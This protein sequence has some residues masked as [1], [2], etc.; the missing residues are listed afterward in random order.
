MKHLIHTLALTLCIGAA[1]SATAGET[2]APAMRDIAIKDGNTRALDGILWYPAEAGTALKTQHTNAVWAGVQA[3]ANAEPIAGNFPLVVLSHGI[4][5]NARNQNWLAVEL[6]KQGYMAVSLNHPGSSTWLRDPDDA[7]Q[8][9]QRPKDVTRAISFLLENP[10]TKQLINPERI[11][12]AGHSLGGMTA[13]QLA[14]ARYSPEKVDGFCEANPDDLLCGIVQM[15]QLGQ[16]VEDKDAIKQ[17]LH[18]PRLKGIA[19]FDLGATQTF[20]P[21]SLQAINV[22]LLVIGAPQENAGSLNL[23]LESRALVAHLPKA[24]TTYMEPSSLSHFDFLGKCTDKAIPILESEVPGDGMICEDGVEERV[25]DHALITEAV[26][27]F[28]AAH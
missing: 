27:E 17:D 8:I 12:M 24:T 11:Y 3:A 2:Y 14:G 19:V 6:V 21:E 4:Y 22:P 10:D 28:F 20:S 1:H 16:T 23:D 18:D 5:G 7:R 15:W 25:I 26:L 9:W 13:M